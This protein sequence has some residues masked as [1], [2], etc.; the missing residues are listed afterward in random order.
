MINVLLPCLTSLKFFKYSHIN[1]SFSTSLVLLNVLF[2]KLFFSFFFFKNRVLI[3]AK[4]FKK[5][6]IMSNIILL[7]YIYI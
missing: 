6:L 7:K 3:W 1:F 4:C 2:F 5:S